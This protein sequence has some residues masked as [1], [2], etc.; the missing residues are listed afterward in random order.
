MLIIDAVRSAHVQPDICSLLQT[1]SA[2]V[3]LMLWLTFVMLAKISRRFTTS[4]GWHA[5]C[6]TQRLPSD[7]AYVVPGNHTLDMLGS[8]L[9]GIFL[10]YAG[11]M[12]LYRI[13]SFRALQKSPYHAFKTGRLCYHCGFLP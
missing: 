12:L 8:R 3:A 2:R 7:L 4:R 13:K 1:H 9:L 6:S 11:L 5:A 10:F